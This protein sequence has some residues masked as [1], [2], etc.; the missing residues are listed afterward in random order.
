MT[1]LYINTK[2]CASIITAVLLAFLLSSCGQQQDELQAQA[3]LYAE[4]IPDEPQPLLEI[5]EITPTPEPLYIFHSEVVAGSVEWFFEK[6]RYEL[7]AEDF[8][9]L[10]EM[11]TF[12]FTSFCASGATFYGIPELFPELRH[13]ELVIIPPYNEEKPATLDLSV[14]DEVQA[15]RSVEIRTAAPL[16]CLDFTRR[17]PFLTITYWSDA[18]LLDEV[19]LVYASVLDT[20]L[21]ENRVNGRVRVY[22]RA[23]DGERVYELIVTDYRYAYLSH[24]VLREQYEAVLFISEIRNGQYHYL[25]SIEIPGRLRYAFSGLILTD[26]TFNGQTDVLVNLGS[27]GMRGILRYAAILGDNGSYRLV[28]SFSDIANP[29]LAPERERI[30][31]SWRGSSTSRGYEMYAYI[32]G[33]FVVTDRLYLNFWFYTDEELY[34]LYYAEGTFW[35]LGYNRGRFQFGRGRIRD[36]Y[37]Y[38]SDPDAQAEE[39]IS[40]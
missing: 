28:E 27:F 35:E 37:A 24:D 15:L 6:S 1:K 23:I 32:D 12:S 22:S 20:D 31:S 34:E 11:R 5:P 8:D 19:D 13:I 17:F 3:D 39:I 33:E 36:W 18:H 25:Q 14:L 16:L 4:K 21:I 10:A 38:D 30:F 9:A 2:L 26:V 29:G 7:T 40:D